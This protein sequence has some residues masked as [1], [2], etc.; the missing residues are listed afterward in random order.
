MASEEVEDE[1]EAV[2]SILD[3]DTI[4]IDRDPG[5]SQVVGVEVKVTPLTASDKDLAHV[6]ATLALFLGPTYPDDP[7]TIDIKVPRGLSEADVDKMLTQLRERASEMIG[8]PLVFELVDFAREF[9]TG[10]IGGFS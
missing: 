6:G 10:N 2:C 1:L 9:L 7:P 4:F 5:G 8:C 3:D